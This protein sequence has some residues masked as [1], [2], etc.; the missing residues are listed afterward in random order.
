MSV[1]SAILRRNVALGLNG[2]AALN[3][4][5]PNEFEIYMCALELVSVANGSTLKYFLFPVMPSSIRETQPKITN[6]RKTV[7]GVSVLSTPNFIPVDISISGNFGRQF[8]LLGD[9]QTSQ[10]LI[11]S[12]KSNVVNLFKN[13]TATSSTFDNSVKTGYGCIKILEDIIKS[14][15]QLDP[16]G[17]GFD[18]IF[19]NLAL[20][21]NYYVKATNLEFSQAQ[22]SNM[23]WNYSLT[24]KAIAPVSAY[25]DGKSSKSNDQLTPDNYIQTQIN[26]VINNLTNVI[27]SGMDA[28]DSILNDFNQLSTKLDVKQYFG[29]CLDFFNTVYPTISDY[30]SGK[31]PSIASVFLA[32]LVSLE[33]QTQQM[34][35]FFTDFRGQCKNLKYFNILGQVEDIDNRLKTLRNINRW[36][37]ASLDNASYNQNVKVPYVLPQGKTLERVSQ[38]VI[39]SQ[40]PSEDWTTIAIQNNLTEEQYTSSGGVQI[41]LEV[42]SI[43]KNYSLSSVVDIIQNKA[44]FGKDIYGKLQFSNNDLQVLSYDDTILQA[45]NILIKLRKNANPDFPQYGL[46]TAMIIGSNKATLNFPVITRQLQQ[47]FATDDTLLNFT[48]L[49]VTYRDDNMFIDFTVENRLGETIQNSSIIT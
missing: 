28:N 7:G 13:G 5:F 19:Y 41:N 24:M 27:A 42:P 38:D 46:Q 36:S 14:S 48:I 22:D 43:N 49:S 30:Y 3:S 37:R 2:K 1:S 21:N 17:Q 11:A 33:I 29:T 6:V 34:F 12:F 44:I 10:E 15:E 31:T 16:T 32:E 4:Q 20:G 18:L 40:N 47:T 25:S 9:S 45:V 39:Q 8:R 26:N 35:Q 23:I